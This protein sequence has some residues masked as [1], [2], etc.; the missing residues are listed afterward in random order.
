MISKEADRSDIEY[1]ADNDSIY[2]IDNY[3]NS[4]SKEITINDIR[5]RIISVPS[6]IASLLNDRDEY[7]IKFENDLIT[8]KFIRGR[9]YFS[10]GITNIYR[11]YNLLSA[12]NIITPRKAT[13]LYDGKII[14][15]RLEK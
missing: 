7:N 14:E 15:I 4:I 9:N 1:D 13:W 10:G 5:A 2:N 6:K 11:K 3:K 8:S 12:D